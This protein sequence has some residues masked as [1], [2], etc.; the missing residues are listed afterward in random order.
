MER[1]VVPT[2][3]FLLSAASRGLGFASILA[4][5]GGCISYSSYQDA[6][7]VREGTSQETVA[8][9]ASTDRLPDYGS[10][11]P[12]SVSS[13]VAPGSERFTWYPVEVGSRF[14][15]SDRFDGAFR[16]SFLVMPSEYGAD[17]TVVLG[18]DVRVA[19]VPDYLVLALPVAF[20]PGQTL[21]STVQVQPGV[22]ATV[23]LLHDLDLNGAARINLF[24]ND[25]LRD[26][27]ELRSYGFNAGF[28]W[29]VTPGLTLRPEVGW[30]VF[31]ETEVT[32][33]QFGLGLSITTGLAPGR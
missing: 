32:Y 5:F 20:V 16:L 23:P 1:V 31:P 17:G 30:L 14:P 33:T 19:I 13:G 11:R 28:G 21:F 9:S 2:A 22:V 8:V 3:A 4:T 24:T 18:G 27:N 29:R 12:R 6:R 25:E 15:I 26:E 7:I 10:D